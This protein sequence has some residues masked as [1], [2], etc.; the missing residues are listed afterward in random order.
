M[1]DYTEVAEAAER[2]ERSG[3]SRLVPLAAALV[4][5]LTALVNLLSNQRSM[6]ALIAKNQAIVAFGHASDTYNYYQAK[7]IKQEVY[8]AALISTESKNAELQKVIDHEQESKQAVLTRA[9]DFEKEANADDARSEKYENSHKTLEIGVTFLE[10]AIVVLS[11]SSIVGTA[12]LPM[13][14]GAAVLIG[15]GFSLSALRV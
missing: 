7:S 12:Y 8:R 14:A 4:A 6:E 15:L 11:I 3:G 10:V 5:V 1:G 9:R 13:I 2:H